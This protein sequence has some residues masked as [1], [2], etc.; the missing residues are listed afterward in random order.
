MLISINNFQGMQPAV[1]DHLLQ[2]NMAS[3]ALN[4]NLR[5]GSL[6]P[7][8]KELIDTTLE[9]SDTLIKTIYQYLE[10]YWFEF[11][12]EVHILPGPI[13]ND[14]TARR[15]FTGIGIPK[16]T[17]QAEA[18]TGSP[19]YPI[20]Y[21]PMTAPL[22]HA[23]CVAALGAG[24]TGDARNIVYEWTVVTSWG[25]ESPPSPASNILS[26][27]QGQTVN[28][29]GISIAWAAS[30][31]YDLDTFVMPA[32]GVADHVYMCVVAGTSSG[33]EPTWGTTV[34]GDTVDG[35]ATWKCFKKAIL[36]DS[37]ATKRVYR[38]ISG[39]VFASYHYI[40]AVAM[41]TTTYI[42][43]ATDTQAVGGVILP[44]S[45]WFGPPLGLQGLTS[46]GRFMAGF[47]GKDLHF[48]EPD[49]PHAYPP[50]YSFPIDFPIVALGS[51]GN[52]LVVGTEQNPYIIQGNHPGVLTPVKFA[53]SHPCVASRGLVSFEGGVAFPSNDGLY[54]V[55]GGSGKIITGDAY[56]AD[57]W[58]ALHPETFIGA[59]HRSRYIAFYD[60]GSGDTGGIVVNMRN[61]SVSKLD[62]EATAVYVDPKTDTLYFNLQVESA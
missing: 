11:S 38:S 22:P 46:I 35:T 31:A 32:A 19:P 29:S 7:W 1:D 24:G 27:L 23:A 39:D 58:Q 43:N 4:V 56:D 28:L 41:A 13:A 62:L 16:K 5:K 34:D 21:Y 15:Y 57:D 47:V 20:N 14:T 50:E 33:S 44:S 26:A 9:Q 2:P 3:H 42:D 18:T 61:G 54:F 36:F 12:A 49:Y 10:A 8:K 53:D 17:N 59:Y 55:S 60:D 37:G 25:E 45:T 6:R 52:A 48:C 51:V 40:G 30:Q